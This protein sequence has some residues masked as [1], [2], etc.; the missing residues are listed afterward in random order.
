MDQVCRHRISEYVH[1]YY[2]STL[3]ARVNEVF[4]ACRIRL[5]NAY[6]RTRFR[7]NAD[8]KSISEHTRCPYEA[9]QIDAQA[10]CRYLAK[11]K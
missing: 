5:M 11:I 10:S 3:G 4:D 9:R 1:R 6:D 7:E 2:S 8:L